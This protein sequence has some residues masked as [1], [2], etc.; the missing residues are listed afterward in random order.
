MNKL[1]TA[2]NQ[3]IE[4][5]ELPSAWPSAVSQELPSESNFPYQSNYKDFTD[6]H[7]VT[8]DG[9]DAKDF[10]DAVLCERTSQGYTLRVAIADVSGAVI[11][12]TAMDKEARKRGTSIYFP[13][14]V[15]PMLPE[16]ISNDICSLVPHQ[17]RNTVVC[18]M[19]FDDDGDINKFDFVLAT[20]E[21]KHRLTYSEVESFVTERQ[22]LSLPEV[23]SSISHLKTLTNIL[24]DKKMQR[25]ALDFE[26]NEP[27][28][29][30][31]NSGAV[32]SIVKPS[33]LFAH[34]MIEESMIAANTCAVLF[35]KSKISFAINRYHPPPSEEKLKPLI[36]KINTLKQ[37]DLSDPLIILK[38]AISISKKE[39]GFEILQNLILQNLPRAVYSVN[40]SGHFGLQLKEYTHFTSPI[41]RYPD[42]VIHRILKSILLNTEVVYTQNLLEDQC[43]ELSELEKRAEQASRQVTQQLICYHLENEIGKTFNS[44]IVS[45]TSFGLFCEIKDFFISGLLHVS[46]LPSDYYL[47][48]EH[49]NYLKGRKRGMAFKVGDPITVRIDN[50]L[51]SERKIV[52]GYEY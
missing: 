52:L 39:K 6:M 5:L 9:E 51:P 36:E 26:S 10:D 8:I 30:C 40:E 31:D 47:Y 32:K 14:L 43:A 42:L 50:V 19:M 17:N 2:I 33:R 12:N 29:D 23:E 49:Q 46:D 35:I 44:K 13:G 28:V 3:A 4:E 34:Q 25:N 45:V 22:A 41:R 21:S 24:L 48:N 11:P 37:Q 7:F 1:E 15:I 16:A 18:Q 20:I 27:Q 38:K